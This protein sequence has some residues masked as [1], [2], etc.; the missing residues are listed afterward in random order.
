MTRSMRSQVFSVG[1]VGAWLVVLGL[2]ATGSTVQDG[3]RYS[4]GM[5]LHGEGGPCT[6]VGVTWYS[7]DRIDGTH[8]DGYEYQVIRQGDA[9]IDTIDESDISGEVNP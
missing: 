7:C 5:V 8:E 4:L 6:I 1:A 2:L 3:P 9:S